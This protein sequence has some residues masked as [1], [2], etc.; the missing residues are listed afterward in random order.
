[1]KRVLAI[2]SIALLMLA[3]AVSAAPP[4]FVTFCHGAGLAGTTK[5]V[6]LTLPYQAVFGQAG[7]FNEDGSP[8]AGH[9]QDYL[10]PCVAGEE[11]TPE[12]SVGETATPEPSVS[13]S[14]EPTVSPSIPDTSMDRP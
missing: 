11:A 12:P 8:N 2:T 10:G 13:P 1:M 4:E 3:T 14:L 7:H 5:F 9:E 6:T